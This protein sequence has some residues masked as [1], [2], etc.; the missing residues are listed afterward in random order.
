[1]TTPDGEKLAE[2]VDR[3]TNELDAM[4]RQMAVCKHEFGKPI[5]ATKDVCDARFIRYEGHGSDPEPVFEY[6]KKEEHGGERICNNC[7]QRQY[8]AQTKPV[9]SGYEPDFGNNNGVR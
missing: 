2:K 4:R 5:A 3:M 7:G 1:M 8:T 9:V 6:T